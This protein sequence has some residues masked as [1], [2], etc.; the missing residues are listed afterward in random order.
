MYLYEIDD[1]LK[2]KYVKINII[3]KKAGPKVETSNVGNFCNSFYFNP[4]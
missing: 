2:E 3:G 4:K 1:S